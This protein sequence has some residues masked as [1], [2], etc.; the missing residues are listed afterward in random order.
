MGVAVGSSVQIALL[1]TPF[2]VLLGWIL[3]KDMDLQF[4]TCE[5]PFFVTRIQRLTIF[6][7]NGGLLYLCPGGYVRCPG[8]QV[9]LPRRGYALW[10]LC[11]HRR[12]LLRHSQ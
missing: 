9:Q 7:R 6:S 4:E 2:L 3:G 8:R 11:H 10:P 5:L 1:V 12:R